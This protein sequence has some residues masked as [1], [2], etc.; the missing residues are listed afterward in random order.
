MLRDVRKNARNIH[1]VT[2]HR[3]GIDVDLDRIGKKQPRRIKTKIVAQKLVHRAGL[4]RIAAADAVRKAAVQ[5]KG[6]V[7]FD[8]RDLRVQDPA[9]CQQFLAPFRLCPR[10]QQEYQPDRKENAADEPEH[11]R[12]D[13]CVFSRA[14]KSDAAARRRKQKRAAERREGNTDQPVE[15]DF[16]ASASCCFIRSS[17]FFLTRWIALSTHLVE[18]PN[19]CAIC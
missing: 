1:I 12:K 7:L 11:E 13:P 14:G 9:V 8:A 4:V 18:R 17:S 2:I 10:K 5:L 15:F 16:H 3:I 19:T 6:A